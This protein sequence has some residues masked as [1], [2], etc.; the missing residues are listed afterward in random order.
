MNLLLETVEKLNLL[1]SNTRGVKLRYWVVWTIAEL[2]V[3]SKLNEFCTLVALAKYFCNHLTPQRN[4]ALISELKTQVELPIRSR[5]LRGLH[6]H[7][8]KF[9]QCHFDV[10]FEQAQ[11]RSKQVQK[12]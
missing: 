4:G 7:C 2:G 8:A 5:P 11:P 10:G 12:L 6:S 9:E 1:D 3:G